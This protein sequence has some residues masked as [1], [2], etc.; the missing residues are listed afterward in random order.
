MDLAERIA[1]FGAHS[2]LGRKI[3]LIREGWN[4]YSFLFFIGGVATILGGILGLGAGIATV[5]TLVFFYYAGK[6]KRQ[7]DEE[8]ER[9]KKE[10][11]KKERK[12]RE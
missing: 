1:R 5:V 6:F 11:I 12:R 2:H 7:V 9:M 10:K 8:R 3:D 4:S